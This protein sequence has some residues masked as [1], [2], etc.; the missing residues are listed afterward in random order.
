LAGVTHGS[1][2]GERQRECSDTGATVS[3]RGTPHSMR[4]WNVVATSREGRREEL[5]A[6]LRKRGAFWRGGY[7]DVIVGRVDDMRPF[8]ESIT[9]G[10]ADD[11]FLATSL[12][13]IVPVAH[14]SA[15]APH[16]L[17]ATVIEMLRGEADNV[18]GRSF[19]VRLERRGLKGVV[20]SPSVERA[21]GEALITLSASRGSPARVTFNDPDVVVVI[22]T[23]GNA[24]GVGFLTRELRAEFP[25]IRVR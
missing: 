14:L 23:T 3:I 18:A 13:K 8:L 16:D 21:V 9:R 19:Y 15:F 25:F 4:E 17:A 2:R 10:L 20:H 24:V 5:L 1:G 11:A 12:T 6:S 7:R 22:E